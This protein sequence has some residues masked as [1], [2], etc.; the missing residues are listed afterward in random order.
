MGLTASIWM[1][2]LS[3]K[4]QYH[5]QEVQ[6]FYWTQEP[7]VPVEKF[8]VRMLMIQNHCT[9]RMG[10]QPQ[11]SNDKYIMMQYTSWINSTP[12]QQ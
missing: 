4:V 5:I 1:T 12:S 2:S 10:S 8:T 11:L 7:L 9:S 3:K 6:W